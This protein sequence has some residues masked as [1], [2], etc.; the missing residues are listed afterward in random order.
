MEKEQEMTNRKIEGADW[1]TYSW[2]DNLRHR[3][4]LDAIHVADRTFMGGSVVA[5]WSEDDTI[6]R[7]GHDVWNCIPR[8]QR[9]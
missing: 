1:L 5:E 3:R 2:W 6:C 8:A 7:V 9:P 4:Y